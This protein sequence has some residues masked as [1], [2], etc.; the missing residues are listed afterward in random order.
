[1]LFWQTGVRYQVDVSPPPVYGAGIE[2]LFDT[3]SSET[4]SREVQPRHLVR[5]CTRIVDVSFLEQKCQS[6]GGNTSPEDQN[7]QTVTR[8]QWTG[9]LLFLLS[10]EVPK[11]RS[12]Y[13]GNFPGSGREPS[14]CLLSRPKGVPRVL[15]QI[16]QEVSREVGEVLPVSFRMRTVKGVQERA[17]AETGPVKDPE[18]YP[19]SVAHWPDAGADVGVDAGAGGNIGKC[20]SEGLGPDCAGGVQSVQRVDWDTVRAAH[21]L[22]GACGLREATRGVPD[23]PNLSSPSVGIPSRNVFCTERVFGKKRRRQAKAAEIR[24]LPKPSPVA[25]GAAFLDLEANLETGTE[26]GPS[27]EVDTD[28]DSDVEA[29]AGLG[30]ETD[31]EV[32]ADLDLNMGTF[33]V[34]VSGIGTSGAGK[35]QV[36]NKPCADVSIEHA[37]LHRLEIDDGSRASQQNWRKGRAGNRAKYRM[38]KNMAKRGRQKTATIRKT[39][40][41]LAR[42]NTSGN[43][44]DRD[45]MESRT[46]QEHK[47]RALMDRLQV[48]V[49]LA[50]VWILIV[51]GGILGQILSDAVAPDLPSLPSA[52]FFDADSSTSLYGEAHS[53]DK[54]SLLGSE[55]EGM[56]AEGFVAEDL[57]ANNPQAET[58]GTQ[59]HASSLP[60]AENP[61]FCPCDAPE[62]TCS[63][64]VFDTQQIVDRQ[65]RAEEK[66]VGETSAQC[67]KKN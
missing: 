56:Q 36:C 59:A 32:E 19:R 8:R 1:M 9:P 55:S 44:A 42:A 18:E 62:A 35:V 30:V 10:F 52:A 47:R 24:K 39:P 11:K 2:H 40:S 28:V 66:N 15:P 65:W 29:E 14:Y 41:D 64:A 43:S 16:P 50:L 7:L 54:E 38:K 51:G 57:A 26:S 5:D 46:V 4:S 25:H 27:V 3:E 20:G 61:L 60:T 49:L 6:G 45:A 58:L 48:A 21:M 12:Q 13:A 31:V 34:G 23:G 22:R 67:E 63:A 17:S 53:S 33:S 37:V